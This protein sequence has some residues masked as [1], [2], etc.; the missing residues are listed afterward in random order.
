MRTR[1]LVDLLGLEKGKAY[2]FHEYVFNLLNYFYGHRDEIRY[3][4]IIIWCKESEEG[5]FRQFDDKFEIKGFKY[6]TYLKK[7]WLQII[8]PI[9]EKLTKEDLLF[10]PGNISGILK[11]CTELLTIHDLLFK[12]K[13]WIPN[14]FMRLQREVLLPISIRKA[15]SIVA[16][17]E[18]TKD[19]IIHYYPKAEGKIEVIYN[20]FNFKK[21]DVNES[22]KKGNP[23]FLAVSTNADYKNQKT[24]LKAYQK[25]CEEG[26]KKKLVFVGKLIEGTES[27]KEYNDL[28]Q[29]VKMNVVWISGISNAELGLLYRDASCFISASKFEGLGMPVVE[30]MSF[31]IPI[32]LSDIPPHREVSLNKGEFFDSTDV[33]ELAEK[34]LSMNFKKRGYGDEIRNKFSEDNTSARYVELINR[35]YTETHLGGA[36][37]NLRVN[38]EGLRVGHAATFNERRLAA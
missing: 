27:F 28:S 4:R 7:H 22:L 36:I 19:D 17:S 20:S 23:Y 34:M 33:N 32:L 29:K 21:Y 6:S 13:D 24:I 38:R 1:L 18:F 30:A 25:Y 11:R 12:R 9:S 2:G 10:S 37:Y 5:L 35:L 31:G 8:L 16:I 3:E 26:G 15:D 14:K